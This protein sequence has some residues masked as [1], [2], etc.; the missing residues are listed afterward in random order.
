MNSDLTTSKIYNRNMN[1]K[2]KEEQNLNLT[3]NEAK[4]KMKE[5]HN[6]KQNI[7]NETNLLRAKRLTIDNNKSQNIV[8]VNN[9][10]SQLQALVFTLS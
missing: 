3:F 7:L 8:Q 2:N 6:Q 9:K 4:T 5:L 1:I 10:G